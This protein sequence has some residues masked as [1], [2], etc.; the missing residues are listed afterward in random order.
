MASTYGFAEALYTYCNDYPSATNDEIIAM[1]ETQFQF[2]G[3]RHLDDAS[4]LVYDSLKRK[5]RTPRNVFEEI[6]DID[7]EEQDETDTHQD[8]YAKER[9]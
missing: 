6:F 9:F 1:L 4:Y 2:S 7:S 5:V 8:A 3:D